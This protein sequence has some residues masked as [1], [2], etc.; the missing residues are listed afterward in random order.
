MENDWKKRLGVV[1]STD[2]D[3]SY[4]KRDEETPDTPA[5]GDQL[6]YVSVDRKNRKGKSVTLVEGFRGSGEDLK[7]LAKTLKQKCG[8]G[9]S[10][11]D[12]EILIQ[13]DFRDRIIPM[14][15]ESGY[16]VKRKGGS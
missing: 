16:N 8:V 9:G 2:P 15:E 12:G 14:L 5:P 6:L 11:K 13:G 3:F 10:A 1:Y 4:D 7:S